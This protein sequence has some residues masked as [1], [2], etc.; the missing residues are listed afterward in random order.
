MNLLQ[1]KQKMFEKSISESYLADCCGVSKLYLHNALK[2]TIPMNPTLEKKIEAVIGVIDLSKNI[3]E[4]KI[5]AKREKELKELRD[6]KKELGC[7]FYEISNYSVKKYQPTFL[8]EAFRG[9]KGCSNAFIKNVKLALNKIEK[10]RKE[11]TIK[12]NEIKFEEPPTE[13]FPTVKILKPEEDKNRLKEVLNCLSSEYGE[14]KH[15]LEFSNNKFHY[16]V[17]IDISEIDE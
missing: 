14:S 10:A 5:E 13:I 7:S 11:T 8:S 4:K 17:E 1:T 9:K 16:I 2:G 3:Q 15:S 12:I 6:K